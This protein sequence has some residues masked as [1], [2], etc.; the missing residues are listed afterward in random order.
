[1]SPALRLRLALVARV[2]DPYWRWRNGVNVNVAESREGQFGGCNERF[3][4]FETRG[5]AAGSGLAAYGTRLAADH[6]RS[7]SSGEGRN[8]DGEC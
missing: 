4:R 3:P 6:C 1:M 8:P 5:E 2:L 7:R